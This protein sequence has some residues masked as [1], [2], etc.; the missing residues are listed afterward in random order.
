[1]FAAPRY[2]PPRYFPPRYFAGDSEDDGKPVPRTGGAVTS[3]GGST[4]TATA[5][6]A[7]GTAVTR[8]S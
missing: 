1:M 3:G 7:N 4:G 6:P 2:F 5:R 8:G